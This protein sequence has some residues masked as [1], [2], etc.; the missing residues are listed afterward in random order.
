MSQSRSKKILAIASGGGHW[1]QLLRL[2]PAFE[3]HHV[4]LVTT[5][6]GL[7]YNLDG[8]MVHI[9]RDASRWDKIGL[10]I[11]ILQLFWL[12]IRLR[13]RVVITT[14]A[15]PGV[16]ALAIGKLLGART[17]WLDSI[18]NAQEL[19]MSGRAAKHFADLRLTQWPEL[20]EEN[21]P[22]YHGAVL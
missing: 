22:F 5:V 20:A 16:V 14:G 17:I 21:G 4:H 6:K 13:P 8:A 11:M 15:A 2:R 12:I 1:V 9:V 7:E 3:G 19:S 18:A 10:V